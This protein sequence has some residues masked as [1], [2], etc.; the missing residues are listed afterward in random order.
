MD[1]QYLKEKKRNAKGSRNTLL[2]LLL[3]ALLASGSLL[4]T[5]NALQK[6]AN[7]MGV[8]LAKSYAA[9]ETRSIAVYQT[10]VQMGMSYLEENIEYGATTEQLKTR[11]RNFF[12]WAAHAAG[13]ENITL[14]AIVDGEIISS[15][16]EGMKRL[17]SQY[18]YTQSEWYKEIV[19]KAGEIV[20]TNAYESA[21]DGRQ[22]V[23]VAVMD[24]VTKNIIVIDVHEENFKQ[25]HGD[26][27]LMEGGAYYLCDANGTLLY[28]QTPLSLEEQ[29]IET[30]AREIS[31]QIA[32]GTISREGG[33]ARTEEEKRRVYY[34]QSDNG[35]LTLVTMP[36]S[37]LFSGLHII[38]VGY[39][40]V[41][42][43]FMVIGFFFWK[44]ERK[45]SQI[46]ERTNDTIRTL[47]NSYYA[48]YRLN[49]NKGVYEMIKGSDQ[50][51]RMIPRRGRYNILLDAL[52]SVMDEDTGRDF[53]QS[54]SLEQ[55]RLLAKERTK[56]FGGDFLREFNGE[57][58]WINVLLL[59]DELLDNGEMV[60][61]F[62][63]VE[64]EKQR[65]LQHIRLMENAL[66]AA[67]ASEKS[68]MQ[69]F[70][71]MSHE[72]RTPLNVIINMAELA[73]RSSCSDV[74]RLDYLQK[75]G[76]SS[77]QLLSLINDIL[78][79]SR[80]K[81]GRVTLENKTFDV[82]E[83]VRI[84]AMPFQEQARME[85]KKFALNLNVQHAHVNGD[86]FRL[87]QILNNLISNALKFTKQGDT[88]SV[89][90]RQAGVRNENYLFI[91]EDTGSGMSKE[92]LPKLF[93]PYE[94]ENRFG[95]KAVS[96][97]GLGMP[98]VKNLISQ[99]GG[100]ITV[101]SKVGKGS[102]FIVSLPFEETEKKV[103][104]PVSKVKDVQ[105]LEG[106]K[107]LLVDDNV[108]NLEIATEL[109]EEQELLVVQAVN[110][111]EALKKF[112]ASNLYEFDAV[113]MDMQ[114]PEM[115]GCEATMAIRAL[116]REDAVRIPI[117]ALTAN[118]FAEDIARTAQA[119]MNAHLSKPIDVT[120]L[121]ST[122]DEMLGEK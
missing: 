79:M 18:D 93:E 43:L 7:M 16:E 97:T 94:R 38:F 11:L 89:E 106:K 62:R 99:M 82:C 32:S 91:V 44:K 92:F 61:C 57:Y 47:G 96:G 64:E 100:Q 114:M 60:L 25:N 78:E 115:D 35:W 102:R 67:D 108:L 59:L 21:I 1:T 4:G 53:A 68:Q 45:M 75:I 76:V 70:S 48:I 88:V 66:A 10:I 55:L 90:L 111:R 22:V 65:Q 28:Y 74:K 118:A 69:F 6:N 5:R 71:N 52:V 120:L 39:M 14:N 50:V 46:V 81:Q 9:D 112:E 85:K 98:I 36:Y 72:M 105:S 104:K 23:S 30:Y 121:C 41:F 109:L 3:L 63:M 95:V 27:T 80:L 86:P 73:Q 58:R 40:A 26:L 13:G 15:N 83:E 20:F 49:V 8:E 110:G 17:G 29:E 12:D 107:I 84:C 103:E 122:L 77:R 113:L 51:R 42:V 101:E 119:G 33:S 24:P 116:E 31:Q 19:E 37:V 117:I 87:T 34:Y 56:D 54:F 2:M